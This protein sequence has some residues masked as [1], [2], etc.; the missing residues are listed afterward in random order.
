MRGIRPAA[1]G[2]P[3]NSRSGSPA[4]RGV[5]SAPAPQLAPVESAGPLKVQNGDYEEEEPPRRFQQRN[6]SPKLS[7]PP[8]GEGSVVS[9]A[10]EPAPA[11]RDL[12]REQWERQ[13][14]EGQQREEEERRQ[15]HEE[16]QRRPQQQERE[17]ER[18]QPPPQP[19]QEISR[20]NGGT[21]DY[22]GGAGAQQVDA[23]RL[24][25]SSMGHSEG[26]RRLSS[27]GEHLATYSAF[28]SSDLSREPT[29]PPPS[30]QRNTSSPPV[31]NPIVTSGEA[32][33]SPSSPNYSRP[34]PLM[35]DNSLNAPLASA[36]EAG[37]THIT[38]NAPPAGLDGSQRGVFHDTDSRSYSSH[39]NGGGLASPGA[40]STAAGTPIMERGGS[41]VGLAYLAPGAQQHQVPSHAVEPE[42]VVEKKAEAEPARVADQPQA[43]ERSA[44]AEPREAEAASLPL[45]EDGAQRSTA[46]SELSVGG[47]RFDHLHNG[48]VVDSPEN[49]DF[50]SPTQDA[51][52]STQ[53]LFSPP[54]LHQETFGAANGDEPRDLSS[55]HG[56]QAGSPIIPPKSPGRD[57]RPSPVIDTAGRPGA[58][59]RFQPQQAGQ[60]SLA[61]PAATVEPHRDVAPADSNMS[62]SSDAQSP[63]QQ[64]RNGGSEEHNIH[65]DVSCASSDTP[66]TI[67]SLTTRTSFVAPRGSTLRRPLRV[68][69]SSNASD[70]ILGR[71]LTHRS[72]HLVFPCRASQAWHLRSFVPRGRAVR[73]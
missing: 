14:R 11:S 4:Q 1:L 16:E 49:A 43:A 25:P 13:Q 27:T 64:Q 69:S 67:P 35:R 58:S 61:A 41:D 36:S 26:D 15:Q 24:E 39:V 48:H 71:T 70:R 54:K 73:F 38:Y 7:L 46:P 3:G 30:A 66:S 44:L 55:G 28:L 42:P 19:T 52:Y 9:E 63:Y 29:P 33:R 17:Q 22:L 2:A 72:S 6:E 59:P 60:Q 18:S 45:Q 5:S 31:V 50:P 34:T 21:P 32:H 47:P 56:D 62:P 37:A 12:E 8:I 53:P 20:S 65:S 10:A 57:R 23:S 68:A 51:P 40:P